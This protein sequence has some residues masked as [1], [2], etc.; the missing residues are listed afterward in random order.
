GYSFPQPYI[1][2]S[3]GGW[4]A[5]F[6]NG[7]DSPSAKACLY[8]VRLSNG[9]LLKKIETQFGNPDSLCNGL[10]TPALVDSD[11]DGLVDY[12]YAGDLR[13]NLWK[14]DLTDEDPSNWDIAFKD[15]QELP[16]PLFQA[17]N[18]NGYAQPITHKPDIILHC[19]WGKKGYLVL[20]GT[21]RYLG[22]DDFSD[23]SVQTIYGIWD[24]ADE[25]AV[26]GKNNQERETGDKYLGRL[27]PPVEVNGASV[28]ELSNLKDLSYLPPGAQSAT[29]VE[30][31]QIHTDDPGV[32]VLTNNAP[33][34]YNRSADDGTNTFNVGWYFDLP[35]TRERIV[36][37]F[38]VRG[39]V[40]VIV[41]S[42]PSQG[43]CEAG[44]FSYLMEID[45]CSGGRTNMTRFDYTQDNVIDA[46]DNVL[47]D[48]PTTPGQRISV[49]PSGLRYG[50]MINYPVIIMLEQNIRE[51]KYISTSDGN[52]ATL[53]ETPEQEGVYSWKEIKQ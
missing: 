27:M 30:Q 4:V 53:D 44:G 41:T 25:W 48:S 8:V 12:A 19:A 38:V 32:R 37:D 2:N 10:S 6:A 40:A 13:G 20:F 1:V 50:S 17:S 43:V 11:S 5:V 23:T 49:A 7:Y 31:R 51:R 36:R 24:W 33:V 28:R 47:V 34:W 39:N 46:S 26:R 9:E 42:V 29:L 52:I 35:V 22:V 15:D 14:F 21:G 16:Q 45:A 18:V 3:R